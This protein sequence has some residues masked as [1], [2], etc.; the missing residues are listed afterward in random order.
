MRIRSD[1]ASASWEASTIPFAVFDS[2][3]SF[4]RIR[5]PQSADGLRNSIGSTRT[6]YSPTGQADNPNQVMRRKTATGTVGFYPSCAKFG[7]TS[8]TSRDPGQSPPLPR[9]RYSPETASRY[10]RKWAFPR[11]PGSLFL[12]AI[13]NQSE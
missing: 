6:Y 7:A 10:F 11:N 3:V 9:F 12:K 13:A 5:S 4:F 1:R 8:R 2:E